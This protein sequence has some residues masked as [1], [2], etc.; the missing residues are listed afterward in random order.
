MDTKTTAAI[1]ERLTEEDMK[2]LAKCATMCVE[3]TS[4]G[5]YTVAGKTDVCPPCLGN[6]LGGKVFK[7]FPSYEA[8]VNCLDAI[9]QR[10]HVSLLHASQPSDGPTITISSF[11]SLWHTCEKLN[12]NPSEGWNTWKHKVKR[13]TVL[14]TNGRGTLCSVVCVLCL[15][16]GKT[17]KESLVGVDA[18]V[19][20]KGKSGNLFIRW[21]N[22]ERHFSRNHK[23][24]NAISDAVAVTS[25]N[26]Q[27]ESINKLVSVGNRA[28]LE[29]L[30]YLMTEVQTT[31]GLS[32]SCLTHQVWSKLLIQ[33]TKVRQYEPLKRAKAANLKNFRLMEM[34][35]CLE[36]AMEKARSNMQCSV[37]DEYKASKACS[38]ATAMHDGW[39]T[40]LKKAF[41]GSIAWIDPVTWQL[42]RVAIGL[43][44]SD[45]GC[46]QHEAQLYNDM[47]KR[48]GLRQSDLFASISDTNNAALKTSRLLLAGDDQANASE[49]KCDLH[50]ASLVYK[51]AWGVVTGAS[52]TPFP[53][54]AKI[55]KEM[56]KLSNWMQ[57]GRKKSRFRDYGVHGD[58]I[59]FNKGADTRIMVAHIMMQQ[60]LRSY[61]VLGDFFQSYPLEKNAYDITDW[62][63]L[64]EFEAVLRPLTRLTLSCQQEKVPS[65][66]M[67]LCHIIS[68]K[69]A[70]SEAT[71]YTVV[72]LESERWTAKMSWR[73]L[74]NKVS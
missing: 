39:E 47:S 72:D 28:Q 60:F 11:K 57:D 15:E 4:R 5:M 68:A 22:M 31:L 3:T 33:A 19:K 21:A 52:S 74:I 6:F 1:L 37:L 61:F 70:V 12:A 71:T 25:I 43:I 59:R 18:T 8:Y 24:E 48:F 56:V 69:Y 53:P 7:S 10:E 41:G 66:G 16:S 54:G 2:D 20:D 26:R 17:L 13:T 38:F 63:Q 67:A 49:E 64:A 46:S 50:L 73:E 36:N 34:Y 44:V 27:I 35:N 30:H 40:K 45:N 58:V 14:Q 23:E 9:L 51:Y 42:H 65:A 55:H 32:D 62:P 29:K